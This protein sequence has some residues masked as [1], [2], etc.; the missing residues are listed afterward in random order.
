MNGDESGHRRDDRAT[1]ASGAASEYPTIPT[2]VS[3]NDTTTPGVSS[4]D[5]V[6]LSAIHIPG[7]T[8][9]E[10]IHR[11]G[12]G[13]VY[14]ARQHS[15]D[16]QVAIKVMREGPFAGHADYARFDREVR[17][18]AQLQHPNIVAIH[19]TGVAA[20]C[21][22]FVMNYIQGHPLDRYLAQHPGSNEQRLALFADICAAV[23][24]AH[25]LGIVHRDLK[26]GN[27][28]IDLRGT[29]YI[30][31]FGLARVAED[32]DGPAVTQTGQFLGSLPWATPEQADGR[33]DAIGPHT[34]VYALG[35][36]LYQILAGAFPYDVQGR[37][38]D[39]LSRIIHAEPASLRSRARDV[40][41]DVET[42]VRKCLAKEPDRRYADAG[43]LAADIRR[44]LAGEPINAR[45]DSAVYV[46][47]KRATSFVRHNPLLATVFAIVAATVLTLTAGIPLVYVWTPTNALFARAA[48]N[49]LP[50]APL[51]TIA[52][53]RVIA[54][55]DDTDIAAVAAAT[56]VARDCL[57]DDVRC[58]RVVHGE[59]MNRLAAAPPAAVAWD[60]RFGSDS[61]HDD[62]FIAGVR[63]L[64]A[65]NC[66]VIVAAKRWTLSAEG[67]PDIGPRIAAATRW[68]C[69]AAQLQPAQWRVPLALQRGVGDPRPS[70]AIATL[71]AARRPAWQPSVRLQA[72]T[73]SLTLLYWRPSRQDPR[74]KAWSPEDDH[75]QISAAR[76]ERQVRPAFGILPGDLV[77]HYILPRLP[78]AAELDRIT[79][80]YAAVLTWS[81]AQVRDAFADRIVIVGD[82]RN[83]RGRFA[84]PDGRQLW[85]TYAHAA[86][87]DWLG[88]LTVQ[89]PRGRTVVF[90][91]VVCAVLGATIGA[92]WP[93]SPTARML[94][95]LIAA[96]ALIAACL[97][98]ARLLYVVHNPALLLLALVVSSELNARVRATSRPY[99][100]SL[101][102]AQEGE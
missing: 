10:E 78:P 87:I 66:P 44:Y 12:Q 81:D 49:W 90:S 48:L 89:I 60:V 52:D 24:E 45:R 21:H 40:S 102:T 18:L 33:L 75:V 63:T 80:D 86:T 84:A 28:R 4:Y 67:M 95:Y 23:H 29:P 11:G 91:I 74:A 7:Y 43:A 34:D 88:K 36:M 98:A 47:R 16:R 77:A 83:G 42:I 2:P 70:L 94:S 53:V 79:S 6:D 56:G 65:V 59:L 101:R 50:P 100:L 92:V 9:E 82:A 8:I 20:G 64:Q 41:V 97:I 85:S 96:I 27:V 19:D 71:A 25:R 3:P 32:V 51:S 22:Y 15:T 54:L 17:I 31:D 69:T 61:P 76:H 46:A 39:V 35:V 68:G 37:L 13:V 1:K 62:A 14:R 57:R 5:P 55:T 38:Q 26:P 58:F 93:R 73:E 99:A 30:L 72:D